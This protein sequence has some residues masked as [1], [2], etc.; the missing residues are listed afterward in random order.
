MRQIN[1]QI[2]AIKKGKIPKPIEESKTRQELV[3]DLF[4]D[5][6]TKLAITRTAAEMPENSVPITVPEI[7]ELLIQLSILTR[8][9]QEELDEFNA[10]ITK[11]KMSEQAAFINEVIMQEAI[12]AARRDGKT[13]EEVL[14]DTRNEASRRLSS[15]EE[16]EK[17]APSPEEPEEERVLLVDEEEIK[18]PEPTIEPPTEEGTIPSEKLS[19]FEIEELKADLLKKGVPAYEVHQIIEQAKHLSRELVEELIKSLGL[20]K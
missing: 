2:K 12:R 11:M 3:A 1:S 8:L 4:N 18:E 9:S 16:L 19:S 17:V 20:E 7:T 6:Y 5:T 10:D 13:V 15:K 14:E